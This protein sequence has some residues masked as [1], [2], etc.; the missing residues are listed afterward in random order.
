MSNPPIERYTITHANVLY[1]QKHYAAFPH[2]LIRK[3][4]WDE[5]SKRFPELA[6][7]KAKPIRVAI[8]FDTLTGQVGEIMQVNKT[9]KEAHYYWLMYG[10]ELGD[11]GHPHTR[12]CYWIDYHD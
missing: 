10:R 3:M 4:Q 5:P 1:A 6:A 7:Y 11:D 12:V 9:L 8:V 2:A